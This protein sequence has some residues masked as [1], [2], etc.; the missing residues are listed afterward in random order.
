MNSLQIAE[1]HR[2]LWLQCYY[3]TYRL[4]AFKNMLRYHQRIAE[5]RGLNEPD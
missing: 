1:F 3:R 5:L 4:V 2:E